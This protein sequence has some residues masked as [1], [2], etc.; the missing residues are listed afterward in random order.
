MY[1]FTNFQNG[2]L[3]MNGYIRECPAM[4]VHDVHDL[5][6]RRLGNI[7]TVSFTLM[8]DDNY[9]VNVPTKNI[10]WLRDSQTNILAIEVD[11]EVFDV[12][13]ENGDTWD[14]AVSYIGNVMYLNV[15]SFMWEAESLPNG[16]YCQSVSQVDSL[17]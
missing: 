2:S 14:W 17:W 7:T 11:F 5:D 13:R 15:K 12:T 9:E 10:K 8:G 1:A 4:L 6:L 16:S 3:L